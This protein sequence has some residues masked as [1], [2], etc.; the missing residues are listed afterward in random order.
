MLKGLNSIEENQI[1]I[2]NQN[3]G[4]HINYKKKTKEQPE[5][6]GATKTNA[7]TYRKELIDNNCHIPNL[8]HDIKRNM[9]GR[10]WF[11]G[12]PKPPAS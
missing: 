4:K 11:N 2:T 7:N 10:T 12:M 8:V 1:R 5:H 6:R 9:V 3:R